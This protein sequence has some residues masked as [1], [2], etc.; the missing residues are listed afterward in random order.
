MK[1]VAQVH[2]GQT[3]KPTPPLRQGAAIK[4]LGPFQRTC[5]NFSFFAKMTGGRK[6]GIKMNLDWNER[7][8]MNPIKTQIFYAC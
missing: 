1:F 3:V 4:N 5:G 2:I 6:Q 8:Y 7:V